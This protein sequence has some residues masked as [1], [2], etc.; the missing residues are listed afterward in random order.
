M[1]LDISGIFLFMPLFSFLF[2]FI[3]VYSVL[4]KTKILGEGWTNLFVFN[5]QE[6]VRGPP[7][8]EEC[9]GGGLAE[10]RRLLFGRIGP[11]NP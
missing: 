8:K 7:Q 6:I 1:V 2:V 3:I 10:R 4:M 11:L 9:N 5:R